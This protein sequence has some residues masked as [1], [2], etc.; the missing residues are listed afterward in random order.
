[1]TTRVCAY[2]PEILV[3]DE[4]T[5]AISG[6]LDDYFTDEEILSGIDPNAKSI[7]DIVNL[8]RRKPLGVI[9][10]QNHGTLQ[11]TKSTKESQYNMRHLVR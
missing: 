2:H 8:M 9:E 5:Y 1:M 11:L 3:G 6:S 7:G 10:F 4:I